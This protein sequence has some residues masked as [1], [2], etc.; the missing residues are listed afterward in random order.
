MSRF[1]DYDPTRGVETWEDM[2]DGKLQI[3]YRQDVEPVLEYTKALRNSGLA[4]QGIKRDMWHYAQ[5]P[6][7]VIME[8]RF[9]HGVDIFNRDH[10][11]K[12]FELINREYPHLKTTNKN[13]WVKN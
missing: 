7:V 8:M 9:K 6:P 12:V 2:Y 4:D 5:I 1:V 13:H 3:H 10:E 11:K